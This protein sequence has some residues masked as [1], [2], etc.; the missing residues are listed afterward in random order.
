MKVFFKIL[1]CFLLS[2]SA[3]AQEKSE[4]IAIKQNKYIKGVFISSGLNSTQYYSDAFFN[5]LFKKTG[6]DKPYGYG[7]LNQNYTSTPNKFNYSKSISPV[8]STGLEFI[9]NKSKKIKFNHLIEVGFMKFSENYNGS[10]NYGIGGGGEAIHWSGKVNDTIQSKYTHTVIS[11]GYK[12]QP[13]YKY[14]FLSLGI[15]CSINMV[16][17]DLQKKEYFN[18]FQTIDGG[19]ATPISNNNTSDTL[20]KIHFVTFPLQLGIGANIKMKKIVLKPA[21]YFTTCFTKGYN[22]YNA[23]LGILYEFLK[24]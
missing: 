15:N 6:I 11:L 7:S 22:F 21:F 12:F 5:Y 18:G 23:S 17:A 16:N 3:L 24:K 13:T 4:N 2:C 19:N 1:F 9:S 20:S 10:G 8:I 14:I